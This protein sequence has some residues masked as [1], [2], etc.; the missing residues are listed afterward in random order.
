[1][2]GLVCPVEG[3]VEGRVL[4]VEGRVLPVEG[5]VCPVEGCVD[6]ATGWE[7]YDK[8]QKASRKSYIEVI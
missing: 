4:P 1:M 5:R 2:D 6:G 8:E 3:C 7:I